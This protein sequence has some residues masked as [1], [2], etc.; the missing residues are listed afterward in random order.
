MSDQKTGPTPYRATQHPPATKR[1]IPL[2]WQT[3]KSTDEDPGAHARI[4]AILES[5]AY[6]QADEDVAFLQSDDLRP[7]RLQLDF[8]KAERG[9]SKHDIR[10]TIVVFGS[11]RIPEP[12]AATARERKAQAQLA[13]DPDNPKLQQACSVARRIVDKSR[14][15]TVAREFA[16]SVGGS[17][18]AH[19]GGIVALM[20]G[21]GPGLMEAANRGAY[22][23]DAKSVGLNISL[24]HEQFPNPYLT[25]GLCFRFH[26]FALRKM[27]FLHRARALVAFPGGYGTFDELFETLTLVQTRKV[28]PIPIILVGQEFWER[29]VD[30]RFLVDEGVIDPEDERLFCYAETAAEIRDRIIDWYEASGLQIFRVGKTG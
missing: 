11:T 18:D 22:D 8:L 6:Q 13:Q 21:G 17:L 7:V 24:P 2:P 4:K 23:V 14:Y 19:D 29:A 20:T 26:Y 30:F 10:H 28:A 25:P 1:E 16:A 3:P 5:A 15:Y 9:L 12:A 27:H